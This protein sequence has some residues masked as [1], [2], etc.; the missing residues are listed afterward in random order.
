MR[1]VA[2]CRKLAKESLAS[3]VIPSFDNRMNRAIS[4]RLGIFCQTFD[5][6][7]V[8]CNVRELRNAIEG[9]VLIAL[10]GT[11]AMDDLPPEIR[12]AA[13]DVNGRDACRR[14]R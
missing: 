3:L 2:H 14:T 4:C 9:A 1:Q 11:I 5:W 10:D 12:A 7:D 8:L 13:G 6:V